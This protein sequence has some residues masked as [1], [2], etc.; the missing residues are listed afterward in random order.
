MTPLVGGNAVPFITFFPAVLFSAWYGGFRVGALGILLSAVA[1]DYYFISPVHS[2]LITSPGD[3]ITVLI[4][5]VV[6][7][8]MALLGHSQRRALARAN[9]EASVRRGGELAERAERQRFE[10][11]LASIGDGV[12]ATDAKGQVSFMN[13]VAESLTGWKREQILG[14][15]LESVFQIMNEETRQQVQNPA[16]RAMLEGRIVGLANHT[17]LIARDGTEIP[18]DDSGSSIR[19]SEGKP[20]GGSPDLSRYYPTTEN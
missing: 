1:A 15:P 16:L 11:T 6:G 17:V 14:T 19:D 13:E 12:I 5:I 18:I 3:Q 2:F 7:F 8:G 4:F 10:T 20:L 9:Q